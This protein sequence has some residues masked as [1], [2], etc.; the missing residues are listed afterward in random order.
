MPGS[1]LRSKKASVWAASDTTNLIDFLDFFD[2][3]ELFA[4]KCG[5]DSP[6]SGVMLLLGFFNKPCVGV[7]WLF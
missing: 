1:L 2:F 4:C 3:F 5:H 6:L 7:T